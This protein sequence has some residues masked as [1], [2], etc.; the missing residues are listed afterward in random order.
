MDLNMLPAQ[1]YEEAIPFLR[2]PY[3]PNLVRGLVV[4]APDVTSAPCTV[5]L[6]A[7]GE[8]LMDRLNLTCGSDWEQD[9]EVVKE[10]AYTVKG[11]TY[12]YC[13][14]HAFLTVFGVVRKDIGAG[15]ADT[16]GKAKM[17]ARAN[18][19]KRTGR[20][21]GPG[22]CFYATEDFLVF[23]GEEPGKLHL[24]GSGSDAH[25]KPYIDKACNQIIRKQYE[26]WLKEEGNE[27]YGLPLDHMEVAEAI[28]TRMR[29]NGSSPRRAAHAP[30]RQRRPA[31]T[32]DPMGDRRP[33]PRPR[34]PRPPIRP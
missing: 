5:G 15:S 26:D 32:E 6:Y 9:F 8:S 22:Q 18:A 27:N 4:N 16:P 24:H 21:H 33:R 20:W 11:K 29:S 25:K 12:Y 13:E 28:M 3:T 34:T 14:V 2:R 7:I 17:N 31:R 23:R 30:Q 1:S 19:W 10:S